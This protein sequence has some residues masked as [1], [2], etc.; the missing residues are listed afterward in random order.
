MHRTAII[1]YYLC[2]D[3]HVQVPARQRWRSVLI[4]GLGA[5]SADIVQA[6]MDTTTAPQ[7]LT[8]RRAKKAVIG[9]VIGVT[10]QW[11]GPPSS[12]LQQTKVPAEPGQL[13][14]AS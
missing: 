11:S 10:G 7:L 12:L 9:G 14:A 13:N 5:R 2:A 1:S 6:K 3:F 4:A 8:L